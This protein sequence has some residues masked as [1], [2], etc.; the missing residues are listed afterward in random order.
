METGKI[1]AVVGGPRSGKSFL[2]KKLA[3]EFNAELF[4]EGEEHDF[5]ERIIENIR[6]NTRPLERIV[7][8]RNMLVRKYLE[9]LKL[10]D[11]GKNVVLDGFWLTPQLYIDVLLEG[12]ENELAHGLGE[13]DAELLGWPDLIVFLKTSE[14]GIRNFVG[15]GGRSFDQ[16]EEVLVD[17]LLPLN[18]INE[19]FFA[20]PM[21]GMKLLTIDRT[22]KDFDQEKDFS[23]L[24]SKIKEALI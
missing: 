9:A 14:E 3:K 18:A 8:F 7:W 6:N 12:F 17:Q 13:V 5:P 4:L 23:E 1:I 21:D 11:Q 2:V 10:K 24:V 19:K 15:L 22:V 20:K 16:S